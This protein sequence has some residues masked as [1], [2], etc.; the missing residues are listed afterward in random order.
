MAAEWP[1]TTVSR[2]PALTAFLSNLLGNIVEIPL[3]WRM[4]VLNIADYESM[5][6]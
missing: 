3:V 5:E 4:D 1:D 6:K 2:A